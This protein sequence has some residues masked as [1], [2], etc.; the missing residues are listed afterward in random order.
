MTSIRLTAD[1]L[2]EAGYTHLTKTQAQECLKE[3]YNT[4]ELRVGRRLAR[5]MTAIQIAQFERRI[6]D[7]DNDG[8]MRWLA[9]NVP[10][11]KEGVNEE[12]NFVLSRLRA[13]AAT[14]DNETKLLQG[15]HD[16]TSRAEQ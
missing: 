12:F 13:A 6:D 14:R 4:L 2:G 3:F 1:L 10:D 8:A 11:Y 15:A 7:D 16:H 5:K 9:E